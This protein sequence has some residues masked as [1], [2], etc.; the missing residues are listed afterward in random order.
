MNKTL[1]FTLALGLMAVTSSF[2]QKI[3]YCNSLAL[4]A[5]LPEVKAADSD[6]Q[7]LATQ[8]QKQGET[9]VKD[10]Q[11][12]AELLEKKN[13]E[14]T[15][16]PKEYETQQAALREEEAKINKYAQEMEQKL[17]QKRE[18]LYKPIL[19]KVNTAMTTVAKE[20]GFILVFDSSSQILLFADESLDVTNLVKAKLSTN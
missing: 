6:L 1:V 13:T 20:G 15:I 4:M 14:G 17:A 16:S 19:D 2:A 18:E 5:E 3:G 9:M 11:A 7:T 12:K 10:L 8:L